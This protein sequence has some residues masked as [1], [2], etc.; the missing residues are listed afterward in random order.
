V[1]PRWDSSG[2]L[3]RTAKAWADLA[4]GRNAEAAE[5][6][7]RLSQ[8]WKGPFEGLAPAHQARTGGGPAVASGMSNQEVARALYPSP[9]TVERHVGSVFMKL[10]LRSAQSSQ[11]R[12]RRGRLPA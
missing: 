10:G 5:A 12:S 8:A 9:R 1:D 11:P 7:D 4:E 3:S 6:L 2:L